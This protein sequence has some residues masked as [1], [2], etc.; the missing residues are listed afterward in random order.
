MSSSAS[1]PPFEVNGKL[2]KPGLVLLGVGGV[3]WLAGAM[4][5]TTA[6]A[7]AAWKFVD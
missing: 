5:S 2:L 1:R 3:A 4:L 7:Q 6:L